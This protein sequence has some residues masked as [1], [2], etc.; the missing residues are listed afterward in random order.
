MVTAGSPARCRRCLELGADLAVDYHT[1]DFVGA[2]RE[3]T[4]G[5]GVDVVLDCIGGPYLER[6]LAA[7]RDG[8]R[9]VVIGLMGGR[10]AELDLATVLRRHVHLLGSTL[11]SRPPEFKRHLVR[12]FVERFRAPLDAGDLRPVID[13]VIPLADADRAHTALADGEVFGKVVLAVDG[14]V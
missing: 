11:R 4:T 6:N 2:A 3:L 8:G 10:T 5:T 13:R 14:T 1:E 9:L 12:R 7:L